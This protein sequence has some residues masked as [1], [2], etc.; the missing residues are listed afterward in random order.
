M[1]TL[2]QAAQKEVENLQAAFKQVDAEPIP[3][4]VPGGL[5]GIGKIGLV[6]NPLHIVCSLNNLAK[7][8][9]CMCVCIKYIHVY[10]YI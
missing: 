7:K 6:N 2:S 10:I 9:M 5:F 1:Q 8:N 3:E 4:P